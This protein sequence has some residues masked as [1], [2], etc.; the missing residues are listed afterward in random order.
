MSERIQRQRTTARR[1]EESHESQLSPQGQ[2]DAAGLDELLAEIDTVL[3]SDAEAYVR[4]FV[5][6]GGQ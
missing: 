6:K 5:Q 3:E 4:G 2:A 1:S